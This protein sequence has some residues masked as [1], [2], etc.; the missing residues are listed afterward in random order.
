M[1]FMGRKFKKPKKP[2]KPKKPT[3]LG[4]IKKNRV[5]AN[6]GEPWGRMAAM[7]PPPVATCTTEPMWE[8]TSVSTTTTNPLQAGLHLSAGKPAGRR[9]QLRPLQSAAE[10]SNGHPCLHPTT[11]L[12]LP[13]CTTFHTFSGNAKLLCL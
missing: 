3:G 4:F 8:Q 2:I 1:E 5:F 10:A 6:P 9:K 12:I 7:A 13:Q 11:K